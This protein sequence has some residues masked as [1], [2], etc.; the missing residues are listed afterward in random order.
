MNNVDLSVDLN[1]LKLKNPVTVAS[2]T[3]GFGREFIDY[4][5]LNNLGGIMVKGLTLE[6]RKG[7]PVPRVAETPMGMLNSVGLQNPGVR[8]FIKNELPFLKQYDTKVIANINGNTIEE[9]CRIADMLSKT[10]VDS[11]ELNISCPNV[12]E[13]GV[14]FGRD[15][16]M[17]YKVTKKVRE[18]SDKHLIV[19]L[20]P[21]VT[22]IKEI[23]LA[24]EKAGADCLS[25]INTLIGM[26]INIDR[27]ETIL[28]RGM[29]GLSG[30]AIKPVAVRM[31]YEVFNT[32]T[33]PVIGMGGIMDYK[34]AI[35]F[36]LAG[37]TAISIGTGNL[38]DPTL[39]IEVLKGIE[40]HL[41][42]K[43]YRSINEIKGKVNI[44]SK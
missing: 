27:E 21:N 23:S 20:S 32:V 11:L 4:I 25:L 12:K 15:A 42:C 43:G 19:K 10:S 16:D 2:G 36:F 13:G 5:D 26:A 1:G 35:E 17:V 31:V 41:I 34:D 14:S 33:I 28:A 9:Y 24:A 18:N 40:E 3:F 38:I 7:N 22:D 29:G 37:A 8:Y 30:P 6:E 44:P 39:S